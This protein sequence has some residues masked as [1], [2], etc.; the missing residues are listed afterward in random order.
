MTDADDTAQQRVWAALYGRISAVLIPF[1]TEDQFGNADYLLV[2][3]NYGHRR[4]TIEI[5]KPRMLDPALVRM[6]RMLL[7]ELPDWEIVIAVDLPGTENSWPRMGLI[8]RRDG[9]VD[10]LQ[11]GYLPVEFQKV[12]FEGSRTGTGYD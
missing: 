4:H 9:I 3:D 2:D 5:H 7:D 8:I 12:V 11:R 10:G 6:L 1:G